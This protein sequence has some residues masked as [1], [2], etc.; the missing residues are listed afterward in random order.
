MR[1]LTRTSWIN[2]SV[3]G[4]GEIETH[5]ISLYRNSYRSKN[6]TKK[7]ICFC[8][9]PIGEKPRIAGSMWHLHISYGE[10]LLTRRT[11]SNPL[12]DYKE[13]TLEHYEER[14]ANPRKRMRPQI[15]EEPGSKSISNHDRVNQNP[16]I[17]VTSSLVSPVSGMPIQPLSSLAISYWDSPEAKILFGTCEGETT[18]Q[19]I[20]N[21]IEILSEVSRTADSYLMAVEGGD[22]MDKDTMSDHEKHHLRLKGMVLCLSLNLALK[23]MKGWCNGWTWNKCCHEAISISQQM[24]IC[25][26]RN[27]KTVERW[28]RSFRKK[29]RFITP[30]KSKHNLPPFL[31]L[32]PKA[33]TAIK[34]YG[35]SNL[36][37]MSIESM[38]QY[39]HRTVLPQLIEE[40]RGRKKQSE[41]QF[42]YEEELQTLL[43]KYSLTN[44]CL[45]TVSSWIKK[46]GFSYEPRKKNYYV[47]GHEK[48][49]TVA[50]R[51]K[52]IERYLERE[53]K[54]YRWIQVTETEVHELEDKN[55]I[56]RDSGYK[57]NHPESG[58]RMREYHVDTCNLFQERM[59]DETQFGGRRSVRYGAPGRGL[60]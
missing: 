58:E 13:A 60:H 12:L 11:R 18:Q 55:L 3:N 22:T 56:P 42:Q 33:C 26:V 9:A 51:W 14:K 24:G 46:L 49:A 44:I 25:A 40:E 29:R 48:Q 47:D 35:N 53:R 45:S 21:Q 10:D 34:A 2:D 4:N 59:N 43:K 27:P 38:S 23:H 16:S 50:Y 7:T 28:Y 17:D 8:A 52:F 5:K 20:K 39:I 6:S 36:G 54:M 30:T 31:E 37:T 41:D 32:N 19:S 15:Q 57:Y 1:L